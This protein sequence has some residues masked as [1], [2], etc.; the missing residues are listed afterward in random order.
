MSTKYD[1]HFVG[2]LMVFRK[3]DEE[4]IVDAHTVI[5]LTEVERDGWTEIQFDD[6]GMDVFLKFR[7]QDLVQAVA[8]M[9]GADT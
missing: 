6:R 3:R 9:K 7:L 5:E 1:N 4:Q 2:K 8:N